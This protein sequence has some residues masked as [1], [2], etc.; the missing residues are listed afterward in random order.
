M[1]NLVEGEGIEI[2]D[3]ANRFAPFNVSYAETFIVPA[4]VKQYWI[5][6]TKDHPAMV[7]QAY[8]RKL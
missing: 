3:A 6:T 8:V 4:S 1:L 7:L 2:H 5:K